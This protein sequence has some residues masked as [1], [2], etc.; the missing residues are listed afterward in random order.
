MKACR[1]LA[2]VPSRII[3]PACAPVFEFVSATSRARMSQFPASV[4][5]ASWSESLVPDDEIAPLP[6]TKYG[7]LNAADAVFTTSGPAAKSPRIS[8][9]LSA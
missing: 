9:S 1:A 3:R 2:A 4:C 8:A 6:L 5:A 7:P